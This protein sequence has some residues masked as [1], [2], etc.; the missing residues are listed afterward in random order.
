MR[1]SFNGDSMAKLCSIGISFGILIPF[2]LENPEMS[3]LKSWNCI[4][5]LVSTVAQC[6]STVWSGCFFPRKSYCITI[7]S[8]KITRKLTWNPMR[9]RTEP[10]VHSETANMQFEQVITNRSATLKGDLKLNLK[11]KSM[12]FPSAVIKQN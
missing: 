10:K 8:N 9:T 3:L 6:Y 7:V 12:I 11:P 4:A 5:F 2:L 1:W